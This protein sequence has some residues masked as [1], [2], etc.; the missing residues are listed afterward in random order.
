LRGFECN[1]LITSAK[2][3]SV[4]DTILSVPAFPAMPPL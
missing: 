1:G 2:G 3:S 4:R